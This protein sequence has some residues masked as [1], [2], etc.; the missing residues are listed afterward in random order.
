MA[1]RSASWGAASW[2]VPPPELWALS[3]RQH[4]SKADSPFETSMTG[5]LPL[6]MR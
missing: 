5:D 1:A 2:A 6:Q 3:Q 4:Q